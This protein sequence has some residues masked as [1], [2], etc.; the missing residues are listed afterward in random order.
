MNATTFAPGTAVLETDFLNEAKYYAAKLGPNYTVTAGVDTMYAVRVKSA[1]EG[2]S[3]DSAP[4]SPNSL[5]ENRG[6]FSC[7]TKYQPP[8][9]SSRQY[10]WSAAL[11][12]EREDGPVGFGPTEY[13][14]IRDLLTELESQ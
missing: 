2:P 5:V 14:A 9:I 8:P 11:S 1:A 7:V 4:R 10:D 3:P 6:G 13:D 12:D